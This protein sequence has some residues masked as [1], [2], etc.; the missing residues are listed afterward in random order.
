MHSF[1][2]YGEVTNKDEIKYIFIFFTVNEMF[3]ITF[4]QEFR[5]SRLFLTTP[6]PTTT[7]KNVNQIKVMITIGSCKENIFYSSIGVW[8]V[9]AGAGQ[10]PRL[11]LHPKTPAPAPPKNT[12]SGNH[13]FILTQR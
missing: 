11:R 4:N 6:T 5:R 2:T 1:I 8:V 12:G 3:E 7:P 10:K 13:V 9:G